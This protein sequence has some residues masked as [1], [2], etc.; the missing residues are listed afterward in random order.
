[1]T[2]IVK[3]TLEHITL[4]TLNISL[5][6]GNR[7]LSAA[8]LKKALGVTIDTTQTKEIM[9]L[10]VKRVFD[11]KE[12]SKLSNVKTAMQTACK[13]VATPFFGGYAVPNNKAKA[14]GEKLEEYTQKAE[15]L[16]ANLLARY[17]DILAKY[18]EENPAWKDLIT[19]GAFTA[20][21]VDERI[22]FSWN[23]VTIA[24]GDSDGLMS[25][26][27]T[28]KVGGLLGDLLVDIA[29]SA[30][31][32]ADRSLNEK[33]GVT[34]RAFATLLRM[35]D[36]LDGF[37]FMDNRV[38]KLS[39]MIRHVLLVMPK[40]GRIEGENLRN[41]VFLTS[42]LENPDRALQLAQQAIETS[43]ADTFDSVFGAINKT[44]DLPVA[45]D[46]PASLLVTAAAPELLT[47]FTNTPLGESQLD[48]P[49]LSVPEP[50]LVY[51]PPQDNNPFNF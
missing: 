28:T 42:I 23:G 5:F 37:V 34:R 1:M 51:T 17:E 26:N 47:Y 46:P 41:L 36:K 40:E 48:N 49:V 19:A 22:K 4:F 18:A 24:A 29:K 16:K 31:E 10:G 12:L 30:K 11:K 3:Q 43:V 7:K 8:D 2:Q 33:S 15:S 44:N 50:Q 27:L 6:H 25:K 32:L 35:A 14:L 21:Y 13:N 45:V 9:S 20:N 39:E 38:G